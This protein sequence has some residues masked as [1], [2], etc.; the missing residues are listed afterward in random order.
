M[1]TVPFQ[2]L[3]GGSTANLPASLNSSLRSAY[4]V[5]SPKGSPTCFLSVGLF[6]CTWAPSLRFTHPP[7]IGV[8][9]HMS[10]RSWPAAYLPT[11]RW[12]K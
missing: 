2:L 1:S 11:L 3:W 9:V 4:R 7:H 5:V 8:V 12:E 6:F 10:Y